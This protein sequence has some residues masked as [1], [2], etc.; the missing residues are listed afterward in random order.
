MTGLVLRLASA[1][2]AIALAAAFA[3]T[4]AAA[5]ARPWHH[6][7]MDVRVAVGVDGVSTAGI[8]AERYT[9]H[10]RPRGVQV[11]IPGATYDH[12]YFDLETEAGVVSQ[13]RQA[14]RD[15]WVAIV[16]DRVGT[17]RSSKPAAESVTTAVHVASIDHFID[18]ISDRYARL[19]IVVV[20]H[21][22]GSVVAEGVAA[23][24]DEVDALVV[25][26]FLYR[27]T[28]PSF[29]GFP[30]LTPAAADPVLGRRNLPANYLTTPPGSRDF[31][32]HLPG[33][34]P[35][36]RAADEATKATTTAAEVPGFA[37]ELTTGTFAASVRVPVIVVVGE[38]DYLYAGNDPKAFAP[39]QERAFGAAPRVD[40]VVVED[41]AHNLALHR[42]ATRTNDL[43]NR[44][45]AAHS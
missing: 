14:A 10:R 6:S 21:S 3:P 32:Y 27:A 36:T 39:D 7:T 11:F 44:W 30:E 28:L 43:I 18:A 15:G 45:A 12:H 40:A 37:A 22:Y 38:H 42:N 23:R 17:G 35:A 31:F 20:G 34:H 5:H 26:G 9:P 2:T 16:L 1:A 8:H 19:P 29:E 24:S 4:P 41:A 33:T 25:T 13:A